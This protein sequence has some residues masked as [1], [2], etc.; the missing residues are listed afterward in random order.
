MRLSREG[1]HFCAIWR[2]PNPVRC[3]QACS[4]NVTACIMQASPGNETSNVGP[5]EMYRQSEVIGEPLSDRPKWTH[6][7]SCAGNLWWTPCILA[8]SWLES[9]DPIRSP[10]QVREVEVQVGFGLEGSLTSERRI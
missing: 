3:A 10:Y 4:V 6:R 5:Q 1:Q 8:L 7:V 2:K 9:G